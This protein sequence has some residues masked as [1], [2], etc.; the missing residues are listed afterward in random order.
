MTNRTPLYTVLAIAM[1]LSSLFSLVSCNKDKDNDDN[2]SYS[3]S[4]QTTLIKSFALQADRDVLSNLD[5][6]KFTID[7]D[8][9]LIY[10]ADS[11]PKG[12]S[13]TALKVTVSFM[14][15]VR[16]AIFNIAG[17]TVQAD[18]AI[19][20]TTSMS[21][22]LDFTGKTVLTVTSSD[23]SQVKDYEIK[24][25]VH[26]VNPDSLVWPESWRRDLPGYSAS[27]IGHKAVRQ[28]EIYRIMEYNGMICNL[29]TAA[30]PG[31][32][33]WDLQ[34]MELPFT[35]QVSSFT[36]TE[37]AL[38]ILATDGTLYMSTD[39]AEWA[40]CGVTWHSLLGAYDGKVLGVMSG[41]DGFYHD[42]YPREEDF[43]ANRVED[44]FPVSGSSEMIMADNKWTLSSQAMIMGGVD[45]N[46]N[47]L[48]DVWGYDGERWGKINNIHGTALPALTGAT[49]FP[50]YTYRTL[51]GTR[52]YAR[53]QTWFLMGGKCAD[54]T[55]NDKI[56]LS[57]TQGVT[58]TEADST[59]TLASHMGKFYGAQAFVHFETLTASAASANMPRRVQSLVTS[60][61]CP[62]IYLFGGYDEESQLLPWVWRGVYV[63][64]TN[65]PL[66]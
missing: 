24:V 13:I 30:N 52:R 45:G 55:L 22:T 6:V 56:Y 23:G 35:P 8:N 29:L 54:G 41:D 61:E 53:Q 2:Y 38:Y 4:T 51:S 10:N 43:V 26:Q 65:Y 1:L 32:D 11:L 5:S 46:G 59:L 28:G 66:Y 15:A 21:Q 3:T 19:N 63:R 17:A 44:G 34:T 39:G 18:T 37:E 9:G 31:E 64:M 49:L 48:S 33:T 12:T 60:W 20:Y 25:L 36:A 42:E 16:S 47:V 7:Y 57:N 40:S 27:T 58:W 50:Y 62:Y 14:N